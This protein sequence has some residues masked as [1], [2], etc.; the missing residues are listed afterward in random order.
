[1][2]KEGEDHVDNMAMFL[3]CGTILLMSVRAGNLVGNAEFTEVGIEMLLFATPVRLD[4]DNLPIEP[5]L[6][7]RLKFKENFE[8]IRHVSQQI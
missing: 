4:R 3:V 6:N 8:H 5:A 7:K 1:M 2:C